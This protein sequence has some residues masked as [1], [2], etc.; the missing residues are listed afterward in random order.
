LK[1]L[2]KGT[3]LEAHHLFEQRFAKMLGVSPGSMLS[4]AL[5]KAEHRVFT[6]AWRKAIP[7]GQGTV[8][9]TEASVLNAAKQIYK[10]HSDILKAI[11]L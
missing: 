5:T 3:G 8:N 11:G 10:K 2:T 1:K 9:A 6:N 7:Y 4:I